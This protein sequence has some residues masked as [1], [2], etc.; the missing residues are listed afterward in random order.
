MIRSLFLV[1]AVAVRSVAAQTSAIHLTVT[2][3]N[4]VEFRIIH[5]GRD[6]VERPLFAR[7]RVELVA[8]LAAPRGLGT[9]QG[10]EVTAL[11]TMSTIHVEATRNGR[12]I[13]GGDGV[14]LTVR[15]DTS[16]VAID[17]RSSVPASVA[18]SLRRPD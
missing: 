12:V 4:Q 1:V 3:P 16:G 17:A 9:V 13:A 6:S 10:M 14:Y 15:H 2:S 5:S 7:G 8:D 11:D 18:R